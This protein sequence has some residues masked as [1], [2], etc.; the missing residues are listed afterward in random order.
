[1]EILIATDGSWTAQVAVRHGTELARSLGG[2]LHVM[3]AY[4]GGRRSSGRTAGKPPESALRIL[5]DASAEA[6][7][8]GLEVMT[9][10]EAGEPAEAILQ[11][12]ER[13]GA[14]LIVVGN[15]GMTGASRFLLGSVPD[16][17]SHHASCSIL[18]V[19]T[20][21]AGD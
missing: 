3:T 2:R 14:D 20:T 18:I 21:G 19:N 12:A 1:M 6:E 5:A 7:R 9:H 4:D 11:V 16:K 17:V 13:E 8:A 10:A 15:K